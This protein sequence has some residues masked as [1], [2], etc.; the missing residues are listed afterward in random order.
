MIMILFFIPVDLFNFIRVDSRLLI[1]DN[2]IKERLNYF[3]YNSNKFLD[4]ISSTLRP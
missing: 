4:K 3:L 2:I 1:N